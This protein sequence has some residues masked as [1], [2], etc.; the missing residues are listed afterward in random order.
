MSSLLTLRWEIPGC[1]DVR[2]VKSRPAYK[3]TEGFELTAVM[4]RDEARLKDYAHR[5]LIDQL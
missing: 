1:T 2:E 3:L 4:R 5:Y